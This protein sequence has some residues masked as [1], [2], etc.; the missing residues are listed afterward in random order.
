MG[1]GT[2]TQ[3][4]I[5]LSQCRKVDLAARSAKRIEAVPAFVVEEALAKLQAVLAPE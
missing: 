2:Q 3:G 5:V 4:A 1:S